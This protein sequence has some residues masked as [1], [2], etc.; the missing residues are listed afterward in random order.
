[1]AINVLLN[2]EASQMV[3][4]G[5][6]LDRLLLLGL[7]GLARLALIDAMSKL[8]QHLDLFRDFVPLCD[9]LRLQL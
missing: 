5:E 8:H 7:L 4:I 1:M 6:F 9:A 3:L 2:D